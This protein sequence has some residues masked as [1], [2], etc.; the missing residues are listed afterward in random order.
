[1]GKVTNPTG[2]GGFQKGVSGNP[3]GRALTDPEFE[4]AIK[5]AAKG[6]IARIVGMAMTSEDEAI[7][8][9]ADI[10]IAER[11]YGK[12]KQAVSLEGQDGKLPMIEVIVKTSV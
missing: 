9:K 6:S 2:K 4:N 3:K 7:R 8:L 10:W 1:M 11:A 12:P 5:E